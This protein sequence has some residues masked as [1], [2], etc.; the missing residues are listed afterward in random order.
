MSVAPAAVQPSLGSAEFGGWDHYSVDLMMSTSVGV[1][2]TSGTGRVT[3]TF[4]ETRRIHFCQDRQKI[5]NLLFVALVSWTFSLKAER[6]HRKAHGTKDEIYSRT[7]NCQLFFKDS[8]S[9]SETI[10][11]MGA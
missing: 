2:V 8:F 9:A 1:D 3:T 7:K 11:P 10:N 6:A 5:G 4:V